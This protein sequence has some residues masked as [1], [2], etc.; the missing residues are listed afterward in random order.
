MTLRDDNNLGG[1]VQR[2]RRERESSKKFIKSKEKRSEMATAAVAISKEAAALQVAV[3][4]WKSASF[5]DVVAQM[6]QTVTLNKQQKE[7]SLTAR[8]TLAD[9]TK[10]F[11]RSVKIAETA[12]ISLQ[13]MNSTDPVITTTCTAMDAL[14]KEC[15]ITVKSYQEEIDNLTRRCKAAEQGYAAVFLAVQ[16]LPDPAVVLHMCQQ[17]LEAQAL[18]IAQVLQTVESVNQELIQSEKTNH[19]YKQ[20]IDS[21]K[22]GGGGG[23]GGDLSR[24]ER[25]ELVSLRKEVAEYEVEF[26]SLKNQDITIRKLEDKIY[27]LQTVGAES[28]RNS[29]E[30][31]RQ[32]LALTEGRRATEALEREAAME[33][34]MQTLELQLRSERAGREATQNDMLVADDM[35]SS[36]EAAWEAQRQILVDDNERVR[37]ALQTV[38]RERDELSHKLAA[39]RDAKAA[40]S[41]PSSGNTGAASVQDLLLERNAYEAE[42]RV[43][44]YKH[45]QAHTRCDRGMEFDQ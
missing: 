13:Q 36:K 43:W 2:E 11:K 44:T 28:I 45:I 21:L 30:Q 29:I 18:Q 9:T 33:A 39:A 24:M 27:E 42:V 16:E 3:A 19:A 34:K 14:S 4:A 26:R 22:A 25:E 37:E 23:G 12:A 32:E 8:K 35:V 41:A 38:K 7:Q 1:E 40:T 20:Q 17:Q 31:A 5:T 10:Q 6:E 15:R